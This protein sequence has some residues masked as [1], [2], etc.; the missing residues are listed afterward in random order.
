MIDEE[1]ATRPDVPA[2]IKE[3]ARQAGGGWLD[4]VVGNHTPPVPL[5]AIRGAW[6]L[7]SDGELTGEYVS[8][9][10]FRQMRRGGCPFH[11]AS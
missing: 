6:K 7:D 4:E 2:A 8:N 1:R 9:P 5:S 10:D 11:R 3:A